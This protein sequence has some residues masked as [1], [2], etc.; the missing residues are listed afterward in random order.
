MDRLSIFFSHFSL[1]ARI[2]LAGRLCGTSSDHRT[3]TAGHLHVLRQGKLT[4][5][6]PGEAPLEVEGPCVLLYIRPGEH[7]FRSEGADIV[8]A[9]VEFG[10]GMF[11]P[12]ASALPKRLVVPL[13]AD[14]PLVPA[15]EC[16]FAEAFGNKDGRQVAV[17]RLAEYFLVLLLRFAI[18]S[19][20]MDGGIL[21][22]LSDRH[23]SQVLTALHR[24]PERA[25]LLE[26]L[27]HIGGMSRARFAAHFLSVVGQTPFEYL[28]YWRVGIA[29]SLLKKG[30][31][32]KMVAPAVG[33]SS[34]GALTRTFSQIVGKPPMAWL[35]SQSE[36]HSGRIG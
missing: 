20:V 23:L 34:T 30:E 1:S 27:A 10:A 8:C 26:E 6:E 21:T 25:W 16:L 15:A 28:T 5:F 36:D 24:E 11:N 7:L 31:P 33:Y 3:V 19:R 13:V 9:F 17:D 29:Q 4:I 12:L 18:D 32:L 2:F 14:S 35:A 22:A